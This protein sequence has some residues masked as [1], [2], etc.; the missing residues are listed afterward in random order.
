LLGE[1]AQQHAVD[2]DVAAADVAE[3]DALGGEIKEVDVAKGWSTL[4]DEQ[5]ADEVMAQ[6]RI[7]ALF[8]CVLA[9][10]R[11]KGVSR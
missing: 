7:A 2:E 6:P 4:P 1:A 11:L 5:E 9:M 8:C 10:L 3:Q